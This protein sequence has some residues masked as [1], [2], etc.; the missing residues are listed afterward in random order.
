MEK[1]EFQ[2]VCKQ[3]A[4]TLKKEGRGEDA[5]AWERASQTIHPAQKID[6]R[7]LWLSTVRKVGNAK[8]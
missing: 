4:C 2:Q 6:D 1:K 3:I 5:S 7:A 8:S